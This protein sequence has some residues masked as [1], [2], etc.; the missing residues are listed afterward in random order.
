MGNIWQVTITPECVRNRGIDGAVEEALNRLKE[1]TKKSLKA[2]P[3]TNIVIG[4][5]IQ[6]NFK[7][8]G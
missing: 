1:N 4:Y 6:Y 8:N 2:Y 3:K 7:E 5:D